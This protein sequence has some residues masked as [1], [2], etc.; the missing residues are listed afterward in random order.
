MDYLERNMYDSGS[1]LDSIGFSANSA[2]LNKPNKQW[3]VINTAAINPSGLTV[4]YFDFNS[5]SEIQAYL[6]NIYEHAT[7]IE[8][9]NI[10]DR[11]LNLEHLLFDWFI[12]KSRIE[13]LTQFCSS[14]QIRR[15]L[16]SKLK[17]KFRR[18]QIYTA[19]K[20]QIHEPKNIIKRTHY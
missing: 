3:F 13:Y 6:E 19:W 14:D 8:F 20:Q 18:I 10:F 5:D 17:S 12:G 7:D 15:E 4:R 9:V 1:K 16:S 11:N 2:C